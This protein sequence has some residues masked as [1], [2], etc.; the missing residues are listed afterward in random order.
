MLAFFLIDL[1][2]ISPMN[3]NNNSSEYGIII[4]YNMEVI[5]KK[6]QKYSLK[7]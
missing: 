3:Y 5:R 4:H 1:D 6:L 7:K 2:K